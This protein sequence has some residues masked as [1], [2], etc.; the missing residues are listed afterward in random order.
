[1]NRQGT[2][3]DT[4][5]ATITS[6]THRVTGAV[7]RRGCTMPDTTTCGRLGIA[8][9]AAAAAGHYV[10]PVHPR[11]KIPAVT[12]W[13][14]A[15]TRDRDRII[16]WWTARPFNIGLSTGRS[17]LLVVDLDL[18]NGQEPP[19][20]WAGARGGFDVLVRLAAA[21]GEA[22]PI[23]TYTVVTPTGGGR[24]LYFRA[25]DDV[26]LRNTQGAL[27]WRI[28]TRGHGG[29]VIAA[30]SVRAE[31]IY[32]VAKRSPI[33]ELPTWLVTALT[34]P[35]APALR[36]PS[37]GA[38]SPLRGGRAEAYLRAV[39]DGECAAVAA[40][41]VGHR[42]HTLLRAAR[43]LGHWVGSGALSEPA[44]RAALIDAAR[45]YLGIGGYTAAQ[46]DR[47]ITDGVT[48]GARF[49]RRVDDIDDRT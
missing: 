18:A 27:G 26:V 28:D 9:L 35:P 47:D 15:A 17:G 12:D 6:L 4:V 39:V 3:S 22:L 20:E 32:R 41:T 29:Y 31:G 30:G 10:F 38:R 1:M 14:G 25:P 34:P 48:Y 8:A 23:C 42:H 2:T 13:E 21:A 46:V 33:A 49:P 19:P 37:S 7:S 45:G 40:A 11:S 16:D 36:A 5:A 43:R 24:H 44:A